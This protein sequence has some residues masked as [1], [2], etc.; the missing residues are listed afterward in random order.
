MNLV[1][2]NKFR[3]NACLSLLICTSLKLDVQSRCVPDHLCFWFKMNPALFDDL[4][5]N[6][7][8]CRLMGMS[9]FPVLAYRHASNLQHKRAVTSGWAGLKGAVPHH[10]AA[11][12]CWQL[13]GAERGGAER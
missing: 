13:Q 1:T 6:G 3:C 8:I 11:V 7:N 4:K 5:Q 12:G 10:A 2:N 9:L